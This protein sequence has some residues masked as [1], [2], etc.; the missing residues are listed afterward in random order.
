MG[1]FE[2]IAELQHRFAAHAASCPHA[3]ILGIGDDAA[4]LSIPTGKQLVVSTD[5]LVADVHF[6]STDHPG[7]IGAK[8]LAVSLSDLAAMG[9]DPAWFF[10]AITL[11]GIDPRWCNDF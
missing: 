4:V 7:D 1:E 2:F 10:L 11:P 9:A 6:F 8:S 5:T 3:P